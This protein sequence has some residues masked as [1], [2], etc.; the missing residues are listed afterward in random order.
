M[1]DRRRTPPKSHRWLAKLDE[2]HAFY[3]GLPAGD[4]AGCRDNEICRDRLLGTEILADME[5]QRLG[6]DRPLYSSLRPALPPPSPAEEAEWHSAVDRF[7]KM[8]EGLRYANASA[9]AH[10]CRHAP[11]RQE[12]HCV[13]EPSLCPITAETRARLGR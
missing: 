8:C 2:M 3:R 10:R 13:G 9:Q 6:L 5:I 7:E 4:E 12:R 11:C 1:T